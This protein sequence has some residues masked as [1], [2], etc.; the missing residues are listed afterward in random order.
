M[1][2]RVSPSFSVLVLAAAAAC[3]A[4]EPPAP[5]VPVVRPV[6][7][8]VTD[9][10]D[11][12]G[13]TEASAAVEV[14]ARVTGYLDKV[15]FKDGDDVK[16]GDVLFE[17][18]PRPYRAELEKAQAV[19]ALA[20]ARL[21]Q[22]DD[23]AKRAAA[24]LASKAVSPE[25]LDKA[26]ADRAEAEA[27]V[28]VARASLQAAKLTL[29]SSRVAAPFDGRVGRRLVD[30]GGLVK[31][32]DTVL[33]VI[34]A[35]D[36]MCVVF[37]VDERTAL[38]LRRAVREGK[39]RAEG[40]GSLTVAMGLADEEG[41]PHSGTVDFADNR[42]D[43]EKGTLRMRAAF[44]NADGL[45]VPGL[46]A[47]VRLTVGKPYK[48]LLVPEEAVGLEEGMKFVLVVGEK[49]V[50]EQRKVDLG[51]R[52]DGWRAVK[53]GLREDDRVVVGGPKGLRPGTTVKPRE[54]AVPVPGAAGKGA[55][56]DKQSGADPIAAVFS[57]PGRITLDDRQQEAL[58]ALKNEYT[59]R[60]EALD[61]RIEKLGTP[62]LERTVGQQVK[63][64]RTLKALRA[65]REKLLGEIEEKKAALLTD[66]QKAP[67]P[68]TTDPGKGP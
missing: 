26:T 41:F 68:K 48:A 4:A 67:P 50:V 56:E 29:E 9:Y 2:A 51:P 24:L 13:R 47:R 31:A 57:F 46:S 10:E 63:A 40:E 23:A 30:P 42:V 52:Q 33:A 66:G 8:E 35:R 58:L 18:D 19:V 55:G 53:E 28:A 15:L 32:D 61:A 62:G 16:K 17:I 20:E 11:F 59:P 7:R 27:A 14:R 44:A 45:L 1:N 22:A 65:E 64:G 21:K 12:A 36:P 60:L 43:P 38:R 5:E 3:T 37:D 49:D 39:P 54:A 34:A 25:D 6:V